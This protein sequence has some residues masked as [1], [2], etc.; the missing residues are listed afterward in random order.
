MLGHCSDGSNEKGCTKRHRR[1]SLEFFLWIGSKENFAQDRA[2]DR[3]LGRQRNTFHGCDFLYSLQRQVCKEG[4]W[5]LFPQTC[6]YKAE[7]SEVGDGSWLNKK[8]THLQELEQV[9][10][11]SDGNILSAEDKNKRVQYI[12]TPVINGAPNLWKHL[13]RRWEQKHRYNHHRSLLVPKQ[14]KQKNFL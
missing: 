12:S 13:S 1:G 11:P 4:G 9:I 8:P 14:P 7:T 6:H 2:Q 3:W 10:W 5:K